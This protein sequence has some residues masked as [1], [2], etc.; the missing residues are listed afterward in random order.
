MRA[1]LTRIWQTGVVGNL[2]TG[3][4][5]VL[6]FVLTVVIIAWM[7]NSVGALIGPGT[8]FGELL[9]RSGEAVIG[10]K[11]EFVAFLVGVI[12]ALFALWLLGLIVRSQVRRVFVTAVDD[13]LTKVPLFRAIYRPVSQVVRLLAGSNA[14]LAAMTVVMCRLGGPGGADIPA[15]L[16]SQT[17]YHVGGERRLLVYLP[18][19]PLPAWGG[20]ALV[21]EAA[22]IPVPDMDAD[23]LIKLYLSF[24][25]LASDTIPARFTVDGVPSPGLQQ[26]EGE[27]PTPAVPPIQRA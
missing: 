9:T 11:S 4:I 27:A 19:S 26:P 6:P 13:V 20:L 17:V 23:H 15:L 16:A 14:D 2:L 3:S 8:W 1:F 18:T 21:P 7:I 25:V 22:V 10:P 24:G 5:V 12:L